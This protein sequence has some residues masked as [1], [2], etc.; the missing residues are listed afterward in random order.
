MRAAGVELEEMRAAVEE[1]VHASLQSGQ[2][3][4]SLGKKVIRFTDK[5]HF[6]PVQWDHSGLV[7][8]IARLRAAVE[9]VGAFPGVHAR[10]GIGPALSLANVI[11]ALRTHLAAEDWHALGAELE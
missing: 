10:P 5:S 11:L 6:F 2:S 8:G 9:A 7:D 3:L 1:E 4:K